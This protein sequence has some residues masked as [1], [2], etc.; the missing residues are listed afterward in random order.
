M[1][2]I[3][4]LLLVT[5]LLGWGGTTASANLITDPSFE[6]NDGV[7]NF[8]YWSETASGVS[9]DTY[10]RTGI[11]AAELDLNAAVTQNFTF[12]EAGTYEYGAYFT[13]FT[14]A[15]LGGW[16]SDRPGVTTTVY[17]PDPDEHYAT[18]VN[19]DDT[20]PTTWTGIDN[21]I[22]RSDWYLISGTF[23]IGAA[24]LG[25]GLLNIYLQS[26]EGLSW[27]VVDD[28]FVKS[29]PEPATMLLLGSGF[30]G[31]AVV[32]RKKFFKK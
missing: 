11:Y 24:D 13:F 19:I 10:A 18:I 32:G 25:A 15:P 16:P 31:L 5:L 14:E 17:G 21:N 8:D 3:L 4:M 20:L 23:T 6:S 2:K 22:L 1:K 30:L 12:T 27:V 29:V 26:Y 7:S 9:V 28:A